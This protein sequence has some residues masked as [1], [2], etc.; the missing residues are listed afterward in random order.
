MSKETT[1]EKPKLIERVKQYFKDT[2]G[3]LRKVSWPT[4]K[5][6]TN[7]TLIV[8]AVTVAMADLPGR[9]GLVRDLLSSDRWLIVAAVE[10]R[11]AQSGAACRRLDD[12]GWR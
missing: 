5:Q 11:P 7:L 12:N 10:V 3:E 6:A 8:L 4:R 1:Q 2:R 9:G